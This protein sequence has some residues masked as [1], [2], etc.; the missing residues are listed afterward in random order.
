MP[1]CI[2]QN[3]ISAAD[4]AEADPAQIGSA[5]AAI[6]RRPLRR[7]LMA[8]IE[9]DMNAGNAGSLSSVASTRPNLA[10]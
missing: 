1:C 3:C 5:L 9:I 6:A 4:L 7:T 2:E 10:L 8:E